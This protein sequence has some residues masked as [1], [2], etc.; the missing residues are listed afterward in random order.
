MAKRQVDRSGKDRGDITRLCGS[1]GS[2]EKGQAIREIEQATHEYVVRVG[3]SEVKVLVKQGASG[4]YLTTSPDARP[5][6]NLDNL[7]N[8]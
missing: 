3:G 8:C 2:T 7:P 6:N 5:P 4:K 1:W